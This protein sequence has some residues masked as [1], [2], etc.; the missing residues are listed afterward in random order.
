M[1]FRRGTSYNT[2]DSSVSVAERINVS[3]GVKRRCELALRGILRHG[4]KGVSLIDLTAH[5]NT[6][7][8]ALYSEG[9]IRYAVLRLIKEGLVSTTAKDTY[10]ASPSALEAWRAL[11]KEMI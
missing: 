4:G 9:D 7:L 1:K 8:N 10:R 2:H 11:P 5:L 6:R 3:N